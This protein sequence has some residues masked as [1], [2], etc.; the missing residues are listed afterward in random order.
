MTLKNIKNY[1]DNKKKIPQ[2]KSSSQWNNMDNKNMYDN[3]NYTDDNYTDITEYP[4]NEKYEDNYK[5]LNEYIENADK[6]SARH[7]SKKM[8]KDMIDNIAKIKELEKSKIKSDITL[9]QK[10]I[11][12]QE[13]LKDF[14]DYIKIYND[15]SDKNIEEIKK[16]FDD[17]YYETEKKERHLVLNTFY[18]KKYNHQTY[19]LKELT[20]TFLVLLTICMIYK[21]GLINDTYFVVLIGT[22]V[23]IASFIFVYRIV[24]III[25][26]KTEYDSY[27][28]N[29]FLDKDNYVNTGDGIIKVKGFNDTVDLRLQN[30]LISSECIGNLGDNITESVNN[31]VNKYETSSK[32]NQ[33]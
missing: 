13:R 27:D 4:Y 29:I 10:L 5:K 9:R 14:N 1:I 17:I 15:T 26:D 23:A 20:F 16:D 22:G 18:E 2:V 3:I 6:D 32:I 28:P 24:S 19:I 21:F 7:F 30:D 31:V 33:L 11:N 8:E 25:K 12:R